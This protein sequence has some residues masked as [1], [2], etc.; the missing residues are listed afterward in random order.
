MAS[1]V[2]NKWFWLAGLVLLGAIGT[3]AHYH[4]NELFAQYEAWRVSR[5]SEVERAKLVAQL[6]PRGTAAIA[7]L[8]PYLRSTD[9]AARANCGSALAELA[10][11]WTA[12]TEQSKELARQ[13]V[14]EFGTFT[15][16]ARCEALYV[17]A[18]ALTTPNDEVSP[19]VTATLVRL[20]EDVELL[21]AAEARPGALLFAI[22]L[23]NQASPANDSV[24]KACRALVGAA[25]HDERA[26]C[27]ANAARLA[28]APGVELL[29]QVPQYI[30]GP[31]PD[32]DAEVRR[33][34]IV[35]LGRHEELVSTEQ[36]LP[37]L[38]DVSGAVRRACE[39][40]LRGR[41]LTDEQIDLARL[42]TDPDAAVRAQVPAKVLSVREVDARIWLDQLS[43]DS[44]PAVRAAVIRAFAEHPDADLRDCVREM[45]ANDPSCTVRQLADYY[46]FLH[47]RNDRGSAGR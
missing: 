40:A 24:R 33:V 9:P 25:V 14:A 44:S 11:Q 16:S 36:L 5:A 39:Q 47:H 23:A 22:R 13:L 2:S 46:L 8:V 20:L 17:A 12:A 19:V 1:T 4:Q 42:M 28:A 27:R 43:R 7:A 3:W 45:A 30:I 35:L 21:T 38:H 41:G 26:E 32:T 6:A 31:K 10:S 37:S 34:A 18:A 29:N 15:A